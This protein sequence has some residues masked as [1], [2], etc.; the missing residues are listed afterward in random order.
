MPKNPEL[1][2]ISASLQEITEKI[3]KPEHN[4]RTS[5]KPLN[6]QDLL[7]KN[8]E[9]PNNWVQPELPLYHSDIHQEKDGIEMGVLENGTPYLSERGLIEMTGVARTTFRRI[10]GTNEPYPSSLETR[11]HINDLLKKS[12]YTESSWFLK[13]EFNGRIVYAYPEEVCLAILEYY[14][15][16]ASTTIPKALESYRKLS[17]AGFRIFIYQSVGYKP[18]HEK[19]DSWK[20]YHDRIDILQDKVPSGYFCIFKEIAGMIVSLIRSGILVS[21]KVIPDISVGSVWGRKWQENDFDTK[22]GKRIDYKHSY[23][24]YYPQSKSNPQAAKAYP[25]EALAEFRKWFEHEYIQ[26]KFP[27]YLLNSAKKGN[28]QLEY[29]KQV[30]NVFNEKRLEKK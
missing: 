14:A 17:R 12:G 9:K 24:D 19:L 3:V 25:N 20:H 22:Y 26:S 7:Q 6:N 2:K 15:F 30:I 21:D 16:D 8:I 10:S 5:A 1:F 28:I 29:A 13:T 27:Q 23:P 11:S 18:Q 4:N